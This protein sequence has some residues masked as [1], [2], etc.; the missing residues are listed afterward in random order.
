MYTNDVD[1]FCSWLP[2]YYVVPSCRDILGSAQ[3]KHCASCYNS[4]TQIFTKGAQ[5]SEC[6]RN[7]RKIY[8]L[9]WIHV[10]IE[11]H[12][13]R[14]PGDIRVRLM[15][16]VHPRATCVGSARGDA[17]AYLKKLCED[18]GLVSSFLIHV[19]RY[20]SSS[21]SGTPSEIWREKTL[22]WWLSRSDT[23]SV[24]LPTA[25]FRNQTQSGRWHYSVFVC[26][27]RAKETKVGVWPG[28]RE[29]DPI[30]ASVSRVLFL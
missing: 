20:Q 19:R 5:V 17:L 6:Y 13:D 4:T 1:F 26:C 18:P 29:S 30:K 11:I 28:W 3:L 14:W 2:W 10:C 15:N 24:T 21:P 7:N 9:I 8:F 12:T 25:Y 23:R 27:P 16:D 22:L